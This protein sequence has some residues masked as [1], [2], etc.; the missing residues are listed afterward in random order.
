MALLTRGRVPVFDLV[1]PKQFLWY[2]DFPMDTA[3]VTGTKLAGYPMNVN[4]D[5]RVA[6]YASSANDPAVINVTDTDRDD[7]SFADGITCVSNATAWVG[8]VKTDLCSN[9]IVAGNY[10]GF[11]PSANKYLAMASGDVGM[12]ILAV[13]ETGVVGGWVTLRFL[14]RDSQRLAVSGD[15]A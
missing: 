14:A 4:S 2:R 5:G 10:V 1:T 8:K 3:N 6:D 13:A 12:Q 7:V 11:D 9:T 15:F